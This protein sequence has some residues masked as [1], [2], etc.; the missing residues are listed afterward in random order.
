MPSEIKKVIDQLAR[1]RASTPESIS[2]MIQ[3]NF[4]KL[5]EADPWLRQVR[6]LLSQP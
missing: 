2:R 1:I 6:T 4:L 3:A 5:I